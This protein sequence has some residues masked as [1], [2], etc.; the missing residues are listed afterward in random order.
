MP[1]IVASAAAAASR[2]ANERS[3]LA[4]HGRFRAP[5]VQESVFPLFEEKGE[6]GK[7]DR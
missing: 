7:I 2:S 3:G 6:K 5:D 4:G 1:T